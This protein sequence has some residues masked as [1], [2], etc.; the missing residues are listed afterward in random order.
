MGRVKA[1]NI[2]YTILDGL[3]CIQKSYLWRRMEKGRFGMSDGFLGNP[4]ECFLLV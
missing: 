2:N 1:I 4:K 3:Y